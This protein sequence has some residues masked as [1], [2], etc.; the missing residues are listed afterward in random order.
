MLPKVVIFLGMVF[1]ALWVRWQT[2]EL[3]LAT[4]IT[5]PDLLPKKE[6]SIAPESV[7]SQI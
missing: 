3:K 7:L 2:G 1:I 5:E 6:E 4:Q